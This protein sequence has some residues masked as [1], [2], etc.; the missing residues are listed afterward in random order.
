MMIIHNMLL[1]VLVT[2]GAENLREA[3]EKNDI[4]KINTVK[5]ITG[6]NI[7][8]I[9]KVAS[10]LITLLKD[11]DCKFKAREREVYLNAKPLIN[12]PSSYVRIEEMYG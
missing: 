9:T 2:N 4:K 3:I 6:K 10:E 12:E 7:S 5:I 1:R 11:I 8:E